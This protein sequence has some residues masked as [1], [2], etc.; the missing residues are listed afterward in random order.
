[1]SA[2]SEVNASA[3][4][5]ALSAMESLSTH[6]YFDRHFH[7]MTA[8][9]MPGEYYWTSRDMAIVT[10]LGSCV[11]AC[12]RDRESGIGGM[13]H[14]MLPSSDESGSMRYGAHAMDVL[15][16][17]LLKAGAVRSN[18]EAKVFG[19]G[20]VLTGLNAL[21][22]GERNAEFVLDYLAA[23]RIRV[24]AQD[25]NESHP[26]KVMFFPHSGRVLVRKLDRSADAVLA[27]ENQYAALLSAA[28]RGRGSRP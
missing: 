2:V 16:A 5:Q 15:I 21:N 27:G 7:C 19:G 26:R 11:S 3:A 22:V 13:N 12:I 28:W 9:V 8:R 14:F 10:V 1:M 25:L 20:R 24:L 6:V 18:L 4:T 17:Q 23:G